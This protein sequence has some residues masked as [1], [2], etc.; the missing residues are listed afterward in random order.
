[1]TKSTHGERLVRLETDIQFIKKQHEAF[2]K[3]I[4]SMAVDIRQM[5]EAL[6]VGKGGGKVALALLALAATI[7]AS[8]VTAWLAS[9]F[10]I[11]G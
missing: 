5:R 4:H 7:I 6:L 2:D 11:K 8:T 1:M 9:K 3:D 10:G